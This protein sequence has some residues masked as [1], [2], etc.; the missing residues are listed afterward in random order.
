MTLW[1]D[2]LTNWHDPNLGTRRQEACVSS[3]TLR[4]ASGSD[5]VPATMCAKSEEDS[6]KANLGSRHGSNVSVTCRLLFYPIPANTLPGL[7]DLQG[8]KG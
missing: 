2:F 7:V 3:L 4:C 6:L 1:S 5:Q 8:I